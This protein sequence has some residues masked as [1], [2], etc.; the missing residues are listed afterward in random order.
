[1]YI[2]T[3]I[4][5]LNRP[6][7]DLKI[8]TKYFSNISQTVP[9]MYSDC[10][11]DLDYSDTDDDSYVYCLNDWYAESFLDLLQKNRE[12]Q[13]ENL[14]EE[15]EEDERK[16]RIRIINGR[17]IET[18]DPDMVKND[19][20]VTSQRALDKVTEPVPIVSVGIESRKSVD[21]L[22]NRLSQMSDQTYNRKWLAGRLGKNVNDLNN[23]LKP[24]APKNSH[25]GLARRAVQFL[26][27]A[28]KKQSK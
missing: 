3:H 12:I 1:M 28:I 5:N 2:C 8:N 15:V 23:S 7:N 14:R 27:R 24:D 19:G 17:E 25:G 4:L 20:S 21:Q 6:K 26:E 16:T 18:P 11:D 9:I 10:S 22:L 13:E